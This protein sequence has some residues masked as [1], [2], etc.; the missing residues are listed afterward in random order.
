MGVYR[1][2][3]CHEYGK[4]LRYTEQNTEIKHGDR[5]GSE[6]DTE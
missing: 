4:I 6:A 3:L 5:A 2:V 1:E